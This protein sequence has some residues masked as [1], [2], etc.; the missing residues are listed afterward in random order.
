MHNSNINSELE[1]YHNDCY[2][3]ALHCCNRDREMASEVLQTS[4]LKI[5]ERQNT[6]RGRSGIKT[7]AFIVIKNTAIDAWRKQ[8]KWN[9]RVCRETNLHDQGYETGAATE[10]DQKLKK[11]FFAEALNQL[12]ERQSQIL[13]LVFYH[14]L[15]LNESAKVLNISQGSARKHY[16]RAKK[17]LADW[18]QKKGI[19]E[20]K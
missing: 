18:F 15:S 2:G 12:S 19:E 7:W 13:Q 9:K 4:Y 8:K 11:L 1:Q 16:D 20:F 14:D 10:F 5:L 6:F 17:S 3:W